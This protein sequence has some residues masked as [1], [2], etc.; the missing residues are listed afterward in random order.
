MTTTKSWHQNSTITAVLL[1]IT[2]I[3]FFLISYPN[4]ILWG[5]REIP[6]Y[7]S[8]A[9]FIQTYIGISSGVIAII[10]YLLR[11]K[12][13]TNIFVQIPI[14]VSLI[15]MMVPTAL[16]ILHADSTSGFGIIAI[17]LVLMISFALFLLYLA[18]NG[19]IKSRNKIT[20]CIIA[21]NL[22]VF[23]ILAILNV[24]YSLN[25]LLPTILTLIP[26]ATFSLIAP[27]PRKEY[28]T[29]YYSFII[30]MVLTIALS[31]ATW[32]TELVF[33]LIP[34]PV[35]IVIYKAIY[36]WYMKKI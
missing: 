36:Y 9:Y 33:I 22:I 28:V 1:A 12:L 23:A 32:F 7:L 25:L 2:S 35:S 13:Q 21:V 20:K 3:I 34:I 17:A 15:G 29:L 8:E 26:V 14:S 19:F 10:L 27:T 16:I 5:D 18:I 11:N 24:T 30:V 31:F 4:W 6:Y